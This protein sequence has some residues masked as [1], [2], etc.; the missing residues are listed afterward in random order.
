MVSNGDPAALRQ[1]SNTVNVSLA[2]A[3]NRPLQSLSLNAQQVSTFIN[4]S[5]GFNILKAYRA[6]TQTYKHTSKV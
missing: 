6:N 2:K 5:I 3:A 1:L 4:H